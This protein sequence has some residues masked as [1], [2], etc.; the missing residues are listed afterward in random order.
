MATDHA[1]AE[2][3]YIGLGANLDNPRAH[4][5]QAAAALT[6]LPASRLERMSRL[7]RTAPVGPGVQPDYVNAAARLVTRLSPTT[8]LAA[9]H[10]SSATTAAC[11]TARAGVRARWTWTSW[12]SAV[13]GRAS[14]A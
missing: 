7:Y 1:V 12:S 8:L 6:H 14:R 5:E 2:T 13:A 3:V 11:A 4:V 10:A 9:L